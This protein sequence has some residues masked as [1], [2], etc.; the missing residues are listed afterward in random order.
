MDSD[1]DVLDPD[2]AEEASPEYEAD[3]GAGTDML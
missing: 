1:D 2:L 3:D